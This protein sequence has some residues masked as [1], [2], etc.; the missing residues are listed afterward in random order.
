MRMTTD[1]KLPTA[2]YQIKIQRIL[3]EY[4]FGLLF[5]VLESLL[6]YELNEWGYDY[7]ILVDRLAA[8]AVFSH[9]LFTVVSYYRDAHRARRRILASHPPPLKEP[10]RRPL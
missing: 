4:F 7:T 6:V 9:N 2:F 10:Y 5:L 8:L 3:N 1:S